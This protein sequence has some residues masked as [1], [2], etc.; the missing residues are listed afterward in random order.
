MIKVWTDLNTAFFSS[1]FRLT[2]PKIS[3]FSEIVSGMSKS[4]KKSC[5]VTDS[6]G[7]VNILVLHYLTTVK[8]A[9]TVT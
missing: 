5:C 3:R 7:N 8:P 4:E 2:E 6:T 9:H 1:S